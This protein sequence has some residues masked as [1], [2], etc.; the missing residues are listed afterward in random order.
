[1]FLGYGEVVNESV[2]GI[3]LEVGTDILGTSTQLG[4]PRRFARSYSCRDLL[5]AI[6]LQ[7]Y[8]FI[9]SDKPTHYCENPA[10]GMPFLVTRKD[11]WRCNDTCRSN[12]RH[13]REREQQPAS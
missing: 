11:K 13:Y 3:R 8:L 6:Y 7:F 1:V 10:C 4:P 2:A 9:T 12:A 5:S